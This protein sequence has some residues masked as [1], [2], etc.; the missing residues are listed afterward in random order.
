MPP[1]NWAINIKYYYLKKKKKKKPQY[2]AR[3]I[4]QTYSRIILLKGFKSLDQRLWFKFMANS[5][6]KAQFSLTI[7]K[8]LILIDN[9]KSPILIDKIKTQFSLAILKVHQFS[10]AILNLHTLGHI[11]VF[12]FLP[13]SFSFC[14]PNNK[15]L[16]ILVGPRHPEL[17]IATCQ[18]YSFHQISL[19]QI[20]H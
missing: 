10:L 20:W 6:L 7:L 16:L 13:S 1:L 2:F 12:Q 4:V 9:T 19:L 5:L 3:P 14:L 18:S 17:C 15:L 8:S 11:L